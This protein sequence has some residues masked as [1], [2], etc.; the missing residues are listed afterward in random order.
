MNK[1][2]IKVT[3]WAGGAMIVVAAV[4]ALAGPPLYAAYVRSTTAAPPSLEPDSSG[5][6]VDLDKLSG[7]WK[8]GADSFAGYR[9][10]EVLN[11]HEATVTGRTDEVSG[12]LSVHDLTLTAASIT[13]DVGSISTPEPARDAYFRDSALEVDEFPTATFSLTA[14][15]TGSR[16]ALGRSQS[17]GVTGDLTLHGVTKSVSFTL[18][19]GLTSDGGQVTGSIPIIFADYGVHAPDLG[20]VTVDE[21]GSIEF[22]LNCVQN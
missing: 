13:V 2:K 8:V 18:E 10:G 21:T 4:V 9:V 19:V 6:S 22:A 12:A 11:G 16:A 20:F 15:V 14:P 3:I 1:K 5:S 17:L 7:D